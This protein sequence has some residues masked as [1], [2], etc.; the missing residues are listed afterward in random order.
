[1]TENNK[2]VVFRAGNEEYA[3]PILF[4]ISF[5]KM[6]CITPIPHLHSYVRG[7]VKVRG[8]LI[9]VVDFEEILYSRALSDSGSAR[10]IVLQTE[11]LSFAVLVTE[12]KEILDFPADCL[13][14]PGLIAYQKT[15]YFTG[16]ANIDHRLITIIDPAK[17]VESLEGIREIKEYMKT[18][19]TTA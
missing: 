5:E 16:V 7:I 3:T 11:E 15:N 1:M 14:Q 8:E 19:K 13:K 17:L 4:V 12:A 18:Q 10:M 2:A 9:P 6:E